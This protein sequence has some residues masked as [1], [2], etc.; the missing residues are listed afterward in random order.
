MNVAYRDC[1]TPSCSRSSDW[2]NPSKSRFP[3]PSTTGATMMVSSS[4]YPAASACPMRSAPPIRYTCL[5]PAA[6]LA[7]S[8]AS[9][10]LPAKV[11]SP[12]PG[13]SPGRPDVTDAL[14]AHYPGGLLL[15]HSGTGLTDDVLLVLGKLLPV[16]D[17]A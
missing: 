4:T 1:R 16:R 12:P 2:V 15:E 10:R 7:C 3:A 17:I 5:A 9:P 13:C 14:A 6:A 8:M 11:N